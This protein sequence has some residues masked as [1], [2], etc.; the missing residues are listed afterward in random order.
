MS[1]AKVFRL[2]Q[3]EMYKIFNKASTWI[4]LALIPV[5][6]LIAMLFSFLSS[7]SMDYINNQMS[8]EAWKDDLR[9]QI[10][11]MKTNN[12]DKNGEHVTSEEIAPE[13]QII[14]E[15]YQYQISSD[16]P[17]TSWKAA[18][19]TDISNK[20]ISILPSAEPTEAQKLEAEKEITRLQDIIKQEDWK[21]Y[22]ALSDEITK[23]S[24]TITQAEKDIILKINKLR[25]DYDVAPEDNSGRS[26]AH[27]Y[28][29]NGV[30]IISDE[31]K[32]SW[33]KDILSQTENSMRLLM[34][35]NN[36]NMGYDYY[37]NIMTRKTVE[38]E[39]EVNI[40]RLKT[41]NS[42]YSD[43]SFIASFTGGP[44]SMFIV[45]LLLIIISGT[46]VSQ[47]F[48]RGTIKFLAVT[49]NRRHKIFTAKL[50]SLLTMAVIFTAVTIM[51]S[52]VTSLIE[53]GFTD[54]AKKEVYFSGGK[55]QE[56][57]VVLLVLRNFGLEFIS[58]LAYA[59]MALMLSTL[60]RN[61]AVSVGVGI[62]VYFIA[63]MV[64]SVAMQLINRHSMGDVFNAEL[65]RYVLFANTNLAS[66]VSQL[67]YGMGNITGMMLSGG[68]TRPAT[69]M[70][71]TFSLCTIAIYVIVML[72]TSYESFNK[73]DIKN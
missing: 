24:T 72:V 16:I 19:L 6:I 13:N 32:N 42:P 66:Y 30:P 23:N 25:I 4:M 69:D 21:K 26:Y 33:K 7:S 1:L 60:T 63:P 22:I 8:Q 18:V 50:L 27:V 49:P 67:R 43:D 47:E 40:H 28:S 34:D 54:I 65:L 71:L 45:L 58:V 55:I 11:D 2:Y 44:S 12:F 3:N 17:P 31:E 29:V 57:S 64:T 15:Q 9:Y 56:V 59:I 46:L 51:F 14:I 48:S 68:L 37:G 38:A 41:N 39:I 5:L 10:E 20:K 70:S 62:A 53:G 36:E 61:T 73:R 52:L 35:P